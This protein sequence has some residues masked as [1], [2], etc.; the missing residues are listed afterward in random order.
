MKTYS[1]YSKSGE[2]M[3]TVAEK[4]GSNL[5]ELLEL[6]PTLGGE[7]EKNTEVLIPGGCDLCP[8]GRGY[9]V[10][11]G[12][13]VYTISQKFMLCVDSILKANPYLHPARLTKGQIIILPQGGRQSN[14][15]AKYQICKG[16]NIYSVS[17]KFCVGIEK[18]ISANPTLEISGFYAGKCINIP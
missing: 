6:N 11:H 9:E 5:Q 8:N 1:Y 12:E 4:F 17:K 16:E 15:C 13:S 2:N 7:L 14:H 3:Q 18:L 10:K